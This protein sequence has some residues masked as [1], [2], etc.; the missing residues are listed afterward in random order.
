MTSLRRMCGKTLID[1]VRNS[2]IRE[3]CGV[4][5]GVV[6]RMNVNKLRWFGHVERMNE[7]RVTKKIHMAER[8]GIRRRGRP[9]IK[10][11]EDANQI[12]KD[13]HV[14][15]T[16]NRRTCMR[17]CMNVSEARNVCKDRSVWLSILSAYPVREAA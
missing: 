14:R 4:N 17:N 9:R 5:V 2:S 13:G 16:L 11:L 1:R 8:K 3:E 7:D 10:W 6:T 15:S 12:L